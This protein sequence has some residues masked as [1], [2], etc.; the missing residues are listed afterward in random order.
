M[1]LAQA[2]EQRKLELALACVRAA[3]YRVSKPKAKKQ[4]RIGPT[5][6]TLFVDGTLC[7]MTTHTSD[8]D[9]DYTRGEKLCRWVWESRHVISRLF[10]QH[11]CVPAVASIHFERDG[12]RL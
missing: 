9:L 11:D 7:R 6:V 1:E 5:C 4:S 10:P 2:L 8:D 12:E 3:G